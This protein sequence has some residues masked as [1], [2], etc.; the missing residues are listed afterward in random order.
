VQSSTA[1]TVLTIGLVDGGWISFDQSLGIILGANVGTCLT[2]QLMA[3]DLHAWACP[4]ILMGLVLILWPGGR[5]SGLALVGVGVMFFSLE[6]LENS[7]EAWQKSKAWLFLLPHLDPIRGFLAGIF[8]ATGFHSS[9]VVTGITMVL[10]EQ[11]F[12]SALLALAVVLGANIGTCATGLLA[13]L[14]SSRAAQ[15]TALAHLLVNILGALMFFPLLPL[16]AP[17][18]PL[19]SRDPGFQITHF[20]TLFNLASSLVFLP[21]TGILAGILEK[22][23]PG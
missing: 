18:L 1:V 14:F 9:S 21:F 11:K 6:L 10:F 22:L 17:L 4:L 2:V 8:M 7:L 20:H 16:L 13:S 19:L 5:A 12:L 23:L 3:L 15:R